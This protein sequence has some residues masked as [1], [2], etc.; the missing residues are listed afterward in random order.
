MT[1]YIKQN[2]TSPS[3]QGTVKDPDGVA[4]VV[5][6]ATVRFHM[7][8]K[9]NKTAK[10]DAA[11]SIV[12]GPNGVVKYDWSAADTDTTGTYSGEF[13][14]TFIDGSVQTYPNNGYITIKIKDDIA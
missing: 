1:F 2:D 6:G 14:I 10:V 13:E 11:G 5:S 7:W 9:Y 3:I 8:G 12:D 4:V